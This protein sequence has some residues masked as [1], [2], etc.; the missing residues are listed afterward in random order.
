MFLFH[1]LANEPCEGGKWGATM[2]V[3]FSELGGGWRKNEASGSISPVK[4]QCFQLPSVPWHW[5]TGDR[6]DI[7]PIKTHGTPK[8]L[9]QTRRKPRE[10]RVEK[11]TIKAEVTVWGCVVSGS[12]VG[13]YGPNVHPVTRPSARYT[14]DNEVLSWP[15]VRR[16][17]EISCC[18]RRPSVPLLAPR[19]CWN[20]TQQQSSPSYWTRYD[21]DFT[22]SSI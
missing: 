8:V 20:R 2:Y 11:Q 9:F 12:A 15:L 4:S 3:P 22:T 6:M 5:W 18:C 13:F 14:Y 1:P 7:W 21:Y 16:S 17:P 10:D 19:F